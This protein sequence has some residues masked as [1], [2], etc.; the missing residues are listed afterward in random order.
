MKDLNSK[1]SLLIFGLIAGALMAVLAMSGNPK[2]MALCTACFI[3]DTAGAMQFHSSAKT[4]YFRP[5]IVG[6]ILGAFSLALY[7]KEFKATSSRSAIIQFFLGCVMMVGALVFLG[8]TLRMI[9]R[10]A[11]GDISAYVGL[12]GLI[13]GVLTG[14]YY[15]KRGYSYGERVE[16]VKASGYLM[17]VTVVLLFIL[18]IVAP[19]LFKVSAEGPGSFHANNWLALVVALVFGAIAY[20]TRLCFTG[21][22]RDAIVFKNFDRL[23]PIL[24]VFLA[25][26]VYNVIVGDFGFKAFG[27]IAHSQH[28]WNILGLYAVGFA[29]ILAG[30]CPVRQIVLA[31]TGSMDAAM[32]VLGMFVGSAFVHNFG[33][34]AAPATK[35]AI[36]G[37]S[38][39]GQIALVLGILILFVIGHFCIQAGKESSESSAQ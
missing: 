25:M 5:E 21:S 32:T 28:I 38:L 4:Q 6:I 17:P 22:I 1:K 37:P 13:L 19:G 34:A 14:S 31:G 10:M 36:G 18:T 9:L 12:I 30:G 35:D 20:Q 15:L 16:T 24:G 3:R 8:C 7:R 23:I 11:A 29:G 39:N 26:F 27:P 2:N 33:I